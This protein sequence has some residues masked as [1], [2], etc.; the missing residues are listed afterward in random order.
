MA[1]RPQGCCILCKPPIRQ[2]KTLAADVQFNNPAQLARLDV[3]SLHAG[4]R[5]GTVLILGYT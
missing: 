2:T 4:A 1:I 3:P 5:S